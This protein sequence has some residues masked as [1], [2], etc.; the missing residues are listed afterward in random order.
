MSTQTKP[1]KLISVKALKSLP[2]A[3]MFKDTHLVRRGLNVIFGP[4][5]SY[6]TFY[7][8]GLALQIAQTD[9]VVYIAAEGSSGLAKRVDAWCEHYKLGGGSLYFICEEIN[10]LDDKAVEQLTGI[11][12]GRTPAIRLVVFDTYAR[13]LV[14]GDENSAK[15]AGRAIFYCSKIQQE[16]SCSTLLIHHTNKAETSERG[17]GA[18]RGGADSMIEVSAHDDAVR[19]ECSKIKDWEAWPSENLRFKQQ[20]DS[21]LLL[22]SNQVAAPTGLGTLETKVLD[23]LTYSIFKECGATAR[24]LKDITGIGNTQLYRVLSSLK[25]ASFIH[26]S[27]RGDPYFIGSLGEYALRGDEIP[28]AQDGTVED[29]GLNITVVN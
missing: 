5:G 4:S 11:L 8:L 15:D 20:G 26:Q 3:Q 17:S 6:K 25:T 29:D 21:G 2:A 10:L 7:A 23:A 27:K 13:C 1:P 24:Q 18:L 22:P 14:G 9:G 12:K 28:R 16:L 19:I